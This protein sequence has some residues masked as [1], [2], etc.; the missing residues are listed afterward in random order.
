MFKI[1]GRALILLFI[2]ILASMFTFSLG[3]WQ[4][5]RA[6]EKEVLEVRRKT[7]W[8]AE[9]LTLTTPLSVNVQSIQF[10]RVQLKGRFL[11]DAWVFLDNR[12]YQ[13]RPAVS[14]IQAFEVHPH[15][16]VIP[17]DRG[18]LLRNPS[19]PRE[20]PV[21]PEITQTVTI[22]GLALER[23]A[24]T[25]ELSGL[26]LAEPSEVHVQGHLWSNFDAQ[27]FAR[28]YGQ[29]KTDFVVMQLSDPGDGLL[30]QPP[31]W[32]SDVGKHRGYAFQ[33]YSLTLVLLGFGAFLLWREVFE[34]N[35]VDS[36]A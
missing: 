21:F 10:R 26:M 5:R 13:G 29:T 7:A 12:Q 27:R 22:E 35:K 6:Q 23:F 19:R 17:V 1:T 32:S 28:L 3:Q 14:V 25:A 24:R 9:A 31:Q 18:L 33:W 2:L 16:L 30:H 20:L 36:R 8:Q 15:G 11:P 34:R 4:T